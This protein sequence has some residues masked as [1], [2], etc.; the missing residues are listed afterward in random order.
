M[1]QR[2]TVSFVIIELFRIK[3]TY[4]HMKDYDD[5]IKSAALVKDGEGRVITKPSNFYT[6]PPKRGGGNTCPG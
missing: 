4:E 6:N 1:F 5:V 3:S 2:R